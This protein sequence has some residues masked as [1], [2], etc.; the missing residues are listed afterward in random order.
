MLSGPSFRPAFVFSIN[1]LILSS[2]PLTFFHLAE[3]SL[4][5]FSRL[6]TLVCA[7]VQNYLQIFIFLIFIFRPFFYFHNLKNVN[8]LWNNN[9]TVHVNEPNQTKKKSQVT[10]HSKW[11]SVILFDLAYKQ[12]NGIIQ[13]W[14]YGLMP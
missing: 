10:S 13:G 2:F 7:V 5:A 1:S 8:K 6:Y 3:V 4:S 9:R 11:P 12:G 14:L